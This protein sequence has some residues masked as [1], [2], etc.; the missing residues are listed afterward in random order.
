MRT[1]AW[2]GICAEESEKAEES[3]EALNGKP[4]PAVQA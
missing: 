3:E 1:L 2:T 4:L